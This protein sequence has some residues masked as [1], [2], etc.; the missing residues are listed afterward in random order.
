MNADI[1]KLFD[2]ERRLAVVI[3]DVNKI[4]S[5]SLGHLYQ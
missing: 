2:A 3:Q 1:A 4:V 5:E